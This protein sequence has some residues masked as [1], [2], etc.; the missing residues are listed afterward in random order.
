MSNYGDPGEAPAECGAE[1]YEI[2]QPDP[3]QEV[4]V[5][6]TE[7]LEQFEAM[8]DPISQCDPY[9]P[10]RTHGEEYLDPE[11]DPDPEN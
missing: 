1:V 2:H 3:A 8:A 10:G 9:E 4:E 11:D 5:L 6:T 7:T